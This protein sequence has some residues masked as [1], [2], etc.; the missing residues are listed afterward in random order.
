VDV[1]RS[2]DDLT[3]IFSDVVTTDISTLGYG[4]ELASEVCLARKWRAALA[5]GAGRY[6]YSDN[7]LVSHYSDTDNSL[8]ARSES[9]MDGRYVGGAPQLNGSAT[10]TYLDY[11][12]WAISAGV[13]LAAMRYVEPAFVRRSERVVMQSAASEQISREFLS[14]ERFNDACTVDLS[15]SRWF[16]IRQSRLS[17]TLSVKNLLGSRN[18]VYG[19]YESSR[20]RHYR[21]GDVQVY[22]PQDNLIT[23]AYPRT[24]YFVATWRF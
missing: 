13:N 4:V 5:F 17:L 6:L 11:S 1:Q 19:G 9:L 8:V 21:S 10:I 7:P 22:R 18:I 2:Y 16:N 12:G 23:N 14:Q 24:I 20:I 15:V 3:T